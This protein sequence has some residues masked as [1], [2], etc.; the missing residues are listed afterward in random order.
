MKLKYNKNKN[1]NLIREMAELTYY[2][3][4]VSVIL[5]LVISILVILITSE[6]KLEEL[7]GKPKLDKSLLKNP[8]FF[9]PARGWL[10]V[11]SN[12]TLEYYREIDP[13]AWENRWYES[14]RPLFRDVVEWESSGYYDNQTIDGRENIIVIHPIDE[15][16]PGYLQQE[17]FLPKGKRYKL[18]FGLTNIAGK[19]IYASSTGC[20]DVGFKIKIIDKNTGKSDVIADVIIDSRS[21]W[22]DF[23]YDLGSKWTGKYIIIR[24]ESYGGGPCGNWSGEWAAVDYVGIVEE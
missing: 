18:Y 9:Y 19:V 2:L 4:I 1:N 10:L 14:R 15:K 16:N 17:T 7:S 8:D 22:R 24:I 5:F 13:V 3:A 23:S 6:K 11:L 20:D 12:D 21:G